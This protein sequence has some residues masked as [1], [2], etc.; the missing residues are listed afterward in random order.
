MRALLD[1]VSLEARNGAERWVW[2]TSPQRGEELH[3]L[4]DFRSGTV[5]RIQPPGRDHRKHEAPAVVEQCGIDAGIAVA[6]L[7]R[8]VREVELDR[9][10]TSSLEVNE[11]RAVPGVEDVPGVWFAVQQLLRGTSSGDHG[12]HATER[13]HEKVTVGVAE[14]RSPVA[15]PNKELSFPDPI[16]EVRCRDIDLPHAGVKPRERV[17]VIGW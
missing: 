17:S 9:T 10:A 11:Q 3:G 8:D 7:R 13:V 5:F 15:A 1:S 4:P 16:R 14:A 6:D 2:R 12:H